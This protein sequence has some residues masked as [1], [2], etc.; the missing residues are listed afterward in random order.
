VIVVAI[1]IRVAVVT[2]VVV[3]A[4]IYGEPEVELIATAK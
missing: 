1:M 4:L 2:T 3:R